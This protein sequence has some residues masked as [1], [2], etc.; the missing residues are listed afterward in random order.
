MIVGNTRGAEL[1]ALRNRRD[2][3][4]TGKVKDVGPYYGGSRVVVVPLRA[5]GGT[6]LKVLE[7]MA[8]GRAVVT[9]SLG[10]EGLD[11]ED[12]RHVMVADG[13]AE[14]ADRVVRLLG[15]GASRRTRAGLVS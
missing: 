15:D 2:V 11:V 12:Q 4:I 6:R 7:A 14:F 9:T 1:G 3:L 10:C 8:L 13:P 5:G